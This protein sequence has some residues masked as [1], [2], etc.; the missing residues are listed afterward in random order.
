MRLRSAY[1]VCIFTF[2]Y[3]LC[4]FDCADAA[5]VEKL[6]GYKGDKGNYGEKV[7]K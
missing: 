7:L 2:T 5:V 1:L 3:N 4:Y 6:R